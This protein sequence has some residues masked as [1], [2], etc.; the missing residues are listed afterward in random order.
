MEGTANAVIG[1]NLDGRIEEMR[2]WHEARA[3]ARL[4]AAVQH[5]WGDRLLVG[6]WGTSDQ[7]G[8]DTASWVEHVRILRRLT[9]GVF[10]NADTAGCLRRE[11]VRHAV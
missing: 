7:F 9:E 5:S 6:R 8:H 4:G 11:L 10:R 2:V 1:R 3:A